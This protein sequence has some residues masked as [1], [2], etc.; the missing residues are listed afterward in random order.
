[1]IDEVKYLNGLQA[2]HVIDRELEARISQYEMAFRMQTSVPELTD[3]SVEPDHV[4]EMYGVEEG[5]SGYVSNCLLAR[6]LVERGVRFVQ[7]YHRGWDHHS[8][9][10]KSIGTR[11]KEASY[12]VSRHLKMLF[13]V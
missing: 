4:K 3:I 2:G 10:D 9:L 11:I 7:L 8:N 5:D 12:V 6:R 1:M 13:K